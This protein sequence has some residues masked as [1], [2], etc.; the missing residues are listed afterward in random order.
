MENV[1]IL[2]FSNKL[3]EDGGSHECA[4][5]LQHPLSFFQNLEKIYILSP[6]YFIQLN[7]CVVNSK[8]HKYALSILAT[9]RL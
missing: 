3:R 6:V 4:E 1:D 5:M 7:I 9:L 8:F 2:C